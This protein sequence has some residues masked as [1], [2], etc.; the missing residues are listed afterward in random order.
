[1]GPPAILYFVNFFFNIVLNYK[2]LSCLA[3]NA[4]VFTKSF[5]KLAVQSSLPNGLQISRICTELFW[6]A[7]FKKSIVQFREM[8]R[9]KGKKNIKVKSKYCSAFTQI[10]QKLLVN[11]KAFGIKTLEFIA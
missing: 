7:A 9:P 5:T 3:T 2:V 11:L 4:F 10:L 1:L 8:C 6:K